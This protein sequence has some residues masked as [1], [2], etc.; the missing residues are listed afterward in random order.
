[1][2]V[3]RAQTHFVRQGNAAAMKSVIRNAPARRLFGAEQS[4]NA[5]QFCLRL[6]IFRPRRQSIYAMDRSFSLGT[7]KSY[8]HLVTKVLKIFVISARVCRCGRL[9]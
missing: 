8:S 5:F 7:V 4:N 9:S 3:T 1:M 2:R 6:T